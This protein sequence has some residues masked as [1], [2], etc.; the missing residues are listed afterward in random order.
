MHRIEETIERGICIGCGACLIASKGLVTVT[1]G[2]TRMYEADLAGAPDEAVRAASR[3]CPFSDESPNE[4]VLR[5]PNGDTDMHRDSYLGQF[6][7]TFAGRVTEEKYLDGSSSG[8]LASWLARRLVDR[9]FV[10]SVI[11]VGR[12]D[13]DEESLFDYQVSDAEGVAKNRKSNYYAATMADVLELVLHDERHFALMG[14]PCF[15]RAARALCLENEQLRERLTFF[16]GLVCGHYKTRAF[17]ESLAWQLGVAPSELSEVD[18]RVKRPG[19]TANDYDFAARSTNGQWHSKRVRELVGGNWGYSAFQPEA[20]NFCDDVVGETADVSFGD[21]WLPKFENDPRG[22]NIVISRNRLIDSLFE[23][24]RQAGEIQVLDASPEDAVQSQAGGF[25]HR[26]EG[27]AVRLA[28]DIA[29]GLSVPRKRVAPSLAD[30]VAP[31]RQALLRQR[32]RMARISH[33]AF[34]KAVAR[35]DLTVYL[36]VINQE[37]ARYRRI[38][39]TRRKR[40]LLWSK[41]RARLAINLGKNALRTFRKTSDE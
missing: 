22:T 14:V 13:H 20:C 34:A 33:S 37:I 27:L 39:L 17:A 10:D 3:V 4:D 26:R 28:D 21:A 2:P 7:T 25:R 30:T 35:R 6:T 16:I 31:Q 32:R 18:F 41:G 23:E 36:T 38:E 1:L 15:I 8:G 5:A 29:A 12:T 9:G 11:H 40:I 24:A 19:R